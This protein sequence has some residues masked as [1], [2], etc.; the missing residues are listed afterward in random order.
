MIPVEQTIFTPPHGNCHA[1]CIASI[2]E[3]PIEKV[4]SVYATEDRLACDRRQRAWLRAAGLEIVWIAEDHASWASVGEGWRPSGYWIAT[5]D[6]GPFGHCTVWRGKR[7]VWNPFPGARED[8][9]DL[10]ALIMIE[11][12][13]APDPALLARNLT[14]RWRRQARAEERAR[15]VLTSAQVGPRIARV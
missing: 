7:M 2:L 3:L 12:F 8:G 10:G 6:V 11:W 4:P 14:G 15:D 1:A 5:N 9:S 13:E